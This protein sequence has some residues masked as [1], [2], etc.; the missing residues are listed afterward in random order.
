MIDLHTVPTPNGHKIS[1]ALEELGLDYT[2]IPY[3]IS[4]GEQFSPE[5]LALNPN[6]KLPVIVDHLDDGSEQTV[7]E[8]GAILIYLAEKTGQ[9][10]SSQ[11]RQRYAQLQWLMFQMAGVGPLQGQAHHFVRYA[12]EEQSYAKQRYL[13][14]SQRQCRVME[15]Q[16]QRHTYIAGDEF[17]IADIALW[18][19]LRAL[20][21]IGIHI[22]KHFPAIHRWFSNL[23]ER[24]AFERGKDVINGW[25]YDLPPNFY[26]ELDDETWSY[27]FGEEQYKERQRGQ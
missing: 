17:S 14:E 8:S 18:P 13:Q 26:M 9:L 25:V 27:S 2:L 4:K 1:I 19:W 20:P 11:P 5:L 6:N 10:L 21:L 16:L 7:F 3:D 23:A 22:D 24:P 15:A 12:R